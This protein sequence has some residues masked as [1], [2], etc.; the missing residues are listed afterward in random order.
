MA[1]N[2]NTGASDPLREVCTTAH[3]AGAW[4]HVD[5]AFGMWAAASP[6][7]RHLVDGVELADSWATDGH[8]W[9]NVPYDCGV[10]ACADPD[11]HRRAMAL[12]ASYL[13][14]GDG[15]DGSDWTAESSRRARA[16]P[17]WAALRSLGRQGIA[18]LV[19]R[20]C[21]HTRRFAEL[22]AAEPDVELLN[23]VVLNQALV[24]VGDA[25]RTLA[26]AAAV[27]REGVTWLG[28]T[29]RRG[30]TALRISVSDHATT[31]EDVEVAA[32]AVVRAIRATG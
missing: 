8:K 21:D 25:D 11:A 31:T 24:R 12:S 6:A 27:Q 14:R 28:T 17:V 26:V 20:C 9:L 15:R 32:A 30:V 16:L 5:G 22:L 18:D 13:A 7:H 2:V 1:G 4:V 10:V 23:E 19:A 3:E 29:V